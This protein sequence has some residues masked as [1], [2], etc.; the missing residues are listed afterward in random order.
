[1]T[2]GRRHCITDKRVSNNIAVS[3][4]QY[5]KTE[6]LYHI[7]LS[8][9]SKEYKRLDRKQMAIEYNKIPSVISSKRNFKRRIR[10]GEIFLKMIYAGVPYEGLVSKYTGGQLRLLN[11]DNPD[12]IIYN[13]YIEERKVKELKLYDYDGQEI[14]NLMLQN[15]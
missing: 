14:E 3:I 15:K 8:L 4:G 11:K 12:E 13:D 1:M 2:R 6:G 9:P 5:D 10:N 7:L